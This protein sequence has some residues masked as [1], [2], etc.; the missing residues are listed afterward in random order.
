MLAFAFASDAA[1]IAHF[2]HRGFVMRNG[3]T[4]DRPSPDRRIE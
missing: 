3:V 1:S 4:R 2:V